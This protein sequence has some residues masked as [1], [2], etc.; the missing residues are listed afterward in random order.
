MPGDPLIIER[1]DGA[2]IDLSGLWRGRSA[3]VACAGES[4][5]EIP[6]ESWTRRGMLS[7]GVNNTAGHVKTTAFVA[8]DPCQKFSGSVWLDPTIIKFIPHP[9]RRQSKR[10][11]RGRTPDGGFYWLPETVLDTP[12]TFFYKRN[13]QFN[14]ETFLIEDSACWGT[15]DKAVKKTGRVKLM[16][17]MFLPL[18]ILFYLGVRRIFL[19]GCDFGMSHDQPYA[20]SQGKNSDGVIANNELYTNANSELTALLPHFKEHG[21]EVYNCA[22][23]SGLHAFPHVPFSEAIEDVCRGVEQTPRLDLWYESKGKVG[24]LAEVQAQIAPKDK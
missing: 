2:R 16:L 20:F 14:P 4:I 10:R 18:R 12:S 15:N 24:T 21:L 22:P 19:C 17:S 11:L 5:N 1:A 9:L 6:T 7:F 23:V 3:F 8:G 13:I